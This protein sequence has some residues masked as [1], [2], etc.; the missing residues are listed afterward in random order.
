MELIN[1][2][3]LSVSTFV[4]A[5][6]LPVSKFMTVQLDKDCT[7]GLFVAASRPRSSL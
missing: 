7:Y 3:S 4:K 2:A 6:M 5:E 1:W